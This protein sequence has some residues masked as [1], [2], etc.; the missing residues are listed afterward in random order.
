MARTKKYKNKQ[1]SDDEEFQL[2]SPTTS[3]DEES[4]D[5]EDEDPADLGLVPA[6]MTQST[7]DA[8]FNLLNL[9]AR[10]FDKK[11][12]VDPEPHLTLAEQLTQ[13]LEQAQ[14]PEEEN[15]E[16]DEMRAVLVREC[17]P[18]VPPPILVAQSKFENTPSPP[19]NAATG[20][21]VPRSS[22]T[23]HCHSTLV[24]NHGTV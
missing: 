4:F 7:S 10:R 20:V 13:E 21:A 2:P 5:G 1:N 16:P 11:T 18:F 6:I 3:S 19:T 23:F 9:G 14:D 17:I 22:T 15:S 12:A 8:V 24:L